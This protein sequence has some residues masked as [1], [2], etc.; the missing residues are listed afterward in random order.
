VL[1]P[2]VPKRATPLNARQYVAQHE[3]LDEGDVSCQSGSEALHDVVMQTVAG[4]EH[5]GR[6]HRRNDWGS[7]LIRYPRALHWN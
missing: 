5:T 6:V 7:E 3:P 2:R 4:L 1:I